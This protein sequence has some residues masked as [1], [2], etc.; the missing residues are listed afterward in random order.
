MIASPGLLEQAYESIQKPMSMT[1]PSWRPPRP[2]VG[3]RWRRWMWLDDWWWFCWRASAQFVLLIMTIN[4]D[5]DVILDAVKAAATR[6]DQ[7]D[8]DRWLRRIM[9][10]WIPKGDPRPDAVERG[11]P[12]TVR[13]AHAFQF[14]GSAGR[15]LGQSLKKPS[16]CAGQLNCY[17][18]TRESLDFLQAAARARMYGRRGLLFTS[19]LK[20][21]VQLPA[22][23]WRS[24]A[25][26]EQRARIAVPSFGQKFRSF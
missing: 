2:M 26:F 7:C 23:D 15:R 16:D 12:G 21:G 17:D 22:A 20:R 25:M 5:P 8:Y 6:A 14:Q 18:A 9:L 11:G 3:W 10:L 1:S 4:D 13:L 24:P 19:P